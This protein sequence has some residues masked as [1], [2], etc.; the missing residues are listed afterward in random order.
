MLH[1]FTSL[2]MKGGGVFAHERNFCTFYL[3][4]AHTKFLEKDAQSIKFACVEIPCKFL[5]IDSSH[6][7][8]KFDVLYLSFYFFIQSS[9]ENIILNDSFFMLWFR[10]LLCVCVCVCVC[11]FKSPYHH[12]QTVSTGV[13]HRAQLDLIQ[14]FTLPSLDHNFQYIYILQPET[15]TSSHEYQVFVWI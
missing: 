12:Y 13:N 8:I 14:D 5:C 1:E 7:V 10:N 9:V 2:F 11:V 6:D 15:L 3:R 4:K